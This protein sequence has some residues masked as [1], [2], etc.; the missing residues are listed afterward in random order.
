MGE[1]F[2]S[3]HCEV[4]AAKEQ[5]PHPTEI[6]MSSLSWQTRILSTVLEDDSAVTTPWL[7][8]ASLLCLR[9]LSNLTV[10][11]PRLVPPAFLFFLHFR[12]TRV[13]IFRGGVR[14]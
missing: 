4:D 6:W 14:D 10:A 12:V 3:Y 8:P 11:H 2:A 7:V 1:N 13:F 5:C 9:L